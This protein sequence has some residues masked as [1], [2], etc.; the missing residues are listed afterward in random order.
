MKLVLTL[1]MMVTLARAASIETIER[2]PTSEISRLKIHVMRVVA[3][4]KAVLI[5]SPGV[6]GDGRGFVESIVWQEFCQKNEL[7]LVGLSFASATKDLTS[8]SGRGY[9][10]VSRES[11]NLLLDMVD[12][13]FPGDLPLILYGFSGGAHFSSR[14]AEWKPERVKAWCAYSAAWWDKPQKSECMPPG[15]VVCGD[16]DASRYGPSLIYFKQGRAL[17]KPWLWISVPKNAHS[18]SV[19]IDKFVRSY[20]ASILAGSAGM[21]V[22]IDMK[23]ETDVSKTPPSLT[24][25]LPDR[26][27]LNDWSTLHEP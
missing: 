5:L 20:F 1:W 10:H 27:L 2:P 9:Y 14:F 24:A 19:P 23:T 12:E 22:D 15:L 26:K 3:K 7:G 16:E 8:I 4:P 18:V 25:W 6:N 13:A 21:W 11:G 17:G